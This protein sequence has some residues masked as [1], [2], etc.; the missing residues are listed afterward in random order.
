MLRIQSSF[1]VDI[2][3]DFINRQVSTK[4]ISIISIFHFRVLSRL[5]G[6]EFMI[7]SNRA[8][9][10]T[11][12]RKSQRDAFDMTDRHSLL[13]VLFKSEKIERGV[14]TRHNRSLNSLQDT[15]DVC[16]APN[17][18]FFFSFSIRQNQKRFKLISN[19][20]LVLL[21]AYAVF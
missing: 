12:C 6:H 10:L 8:T 18:T 1:V 19:A 3:K 11:R 7:A 4:L 17:P 14:C 2:A 21:D 15:H 16:V 20:L 13:S 5:I 9:N